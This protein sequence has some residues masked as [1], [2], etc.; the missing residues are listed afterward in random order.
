M[1]LALI[2]LIGSILM[3]ISILA[4]K[5]SYKLGVPTLILFLFVGIMAG[6]EGIGG[7]E[8]DNANL[9]NTIGVIALNIILFSGGLGTR[10]KAVKPIVYKGGMLATFGVF[11]TAGTVGL[12]SYYFFDFTLAEGLL[13]GAI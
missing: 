10:W 8:F 5:T 2:L 11:L 6:S 3:L 12:F 13:L 1:N 7:I 9:A 4:G